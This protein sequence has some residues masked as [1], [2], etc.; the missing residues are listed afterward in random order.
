MTRHSILFGIQTYEA[1]DHLTNLKSPGNDVK[2]MSEVLNNEKY[3]GKC[4]RNLPLTDVTYNE[5]TTALADF[6]EN[7][8]PN[9]VF[10]FY[11][12]GHGMRN[13]KGDLFLCFRDSMDN[14]LS[15]T[16]LGYNRLREHFEEKKLRRVL[17]ILDCCYSGAALR[18]S[19]LDELKKIEHNFG[20]GKGYFV[21]SSTGSSQIAKEGDE[22]GVFTRH[23]VEGIRTGHADTNQTG[24]ISVQD[25][26]LYL[27]KKVPE[28]VPGQTPM[29]GSEAMTGKFILAL[30]YERQQELQAEREA[31]ARLAVFR[32][33]DKRLRAAYLKNDATRELINSV[34]NWKEANAN[35]L[36]DAPAFLALK[37]YAEKTNG[38]VIFAERWKDAI[39]EADDTYQTTAKAVAE[40][41]ITAGKQAK[42]DQEAELGM[43]SMRADG[44]F[45][46]PPDGDRPRQQAPEPLRANDVSN[47]AAAPVRLP[48]ARETTRQPLDILIEI[49]EARGTHHSGMQRKEL[50]AAL[51]EKV[52][53]QTAGRMIANFL[54]EGLI[55]RH[56]GDS[57]RFTVA[58]TNMVHKYRQGK[59]NG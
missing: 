14:R 24:E 42:A 57:Y 32:A 44:A 48:Q 20:D 30:N 4:V 22:N 12:A 2:I 23:F 41:R 25:M 8:K 54:A 52:D 7:V 38:I 10:I 28:E 55:T 43:V 35:T 18:S 50:D 19:P 53:T 39:S 40:A 47:V 11:F 21:M 13:D 15:F 27:Q 37:N 33:A 3:S 58:F 1:S 29:L 49:A 6:L 56:Q 17:V 46:S 34:A 51:N 5:A 31:Q 16:A 59:N 36:L 45:A 9:D 26:A